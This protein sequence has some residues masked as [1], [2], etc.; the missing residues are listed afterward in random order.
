MIFITGSPAS[1][2]ETT[3]QSNVGK[4]CNWCNFTVAT[5]NKLTANRTTVTFSL[6]Q[7]ACTRQQI[8]LSLH[9]EYI[10]P[11]FFLQVEPMFFLIVFRCILHLFAFFCMFHFAEQI[12]C[13]ENRHKFT[14][15][16]YMHMTTSCWQ[17]W[18][19]IILPN[20]ATQTLPHLVFDGSLLF[21]V[22]PRFL[23]FL[24]FFPTCFHMLNFSA[25]LSIFEQ[26]WAR[27]AGT[28]Q[29]FSEYC[30][31]FWAILSKIEEDTPAPSNT[32]YSFNL[33]RI[34][35]VVNF[36]KQV[37]EKIE[38]DWPF[39]QHPTHDLSKRQIFYSKVTFFH[40]FSHF[41]AIWVFL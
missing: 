2:A 22:V 7:S 35:I 41:W 12:R 24:L 10:I 19:D 37:W 38:Q 29:N 11:L 26:F 17:W 8:V 39:E 21:Q 23:L 28:H 27:L 34:R 9:I 20:H 33:L 40:F 13:R 3:R 25:L 30:E 15:S 31:F 6:S 1:P 32:L 5:A 36:F 4:W 14:Q 16:L 18:C